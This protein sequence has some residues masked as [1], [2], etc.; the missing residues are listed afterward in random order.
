MSENSLRI[1]FAGTPDFAALHLKAIFD[2]KHQLLA[3]YTQPDRPAGRGKKLRASPVK[4]LAEGAGLTIHQP[5][6]LKEEGEQ[7]RLAALQADVIVVVAYGLILPQAILDTPRLGCLNVHASLLP[8]WRG[9]A[10]I[11]R[12]IEAGDPAT[13]ITIMQMDAGLD[14][15]DM[16]ATATCPIH[17]DSTAASLHDDLAQLGTGLLMQVLGDLPGHQGKACQQDD[18]Q[19]TY[20]N[21][22]LKPEAEIDWRL[23]A[24]VLDRTI[25]AFNPFPICFSTLGGERVKIWQAVPAGTMKLPET[26]GTVLRADRDGI[27]VNCGRGQLSIQRL[28]FPGGKP[29]TTEQVLN[30]R[31]EL[32]SP[33]ATFDLPAMNPGAG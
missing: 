13:G 31:S 23:D 26:A 4:H 12:A 29:L 2:S 1:V 22:I 10:P 24:Q 19:A 18:E 16:L 21:K 25:R 33:G 20:A 14:T 8:R 17:G 6:S 32:L 3:V 9:A 15:G 11:Q 28:Q 27:L 30:A 5:L 7:L